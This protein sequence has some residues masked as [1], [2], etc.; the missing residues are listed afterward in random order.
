MDLLIVYIIQNEF[1]FI[2]QSGLG[3]CIMQ[4]NKSIKNSVLKSAFQYSLW[5]NKLSGI[6]LLGVEFTYE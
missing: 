1:F 4:T 6:Q 2:S 3:H 5:Q